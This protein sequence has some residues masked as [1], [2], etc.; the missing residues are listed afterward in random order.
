MKAILALILLALP[1]L[2]Q[3]SV[4]DEIAALEA[5]KA[6]NPPQLL[7]GSGRLKSSR[8]S[9]SAGRC[10]TRL[11][12]ISTAARK[13]PCRRAGNGDGKWS[14][15]NLTMTGSVISR[16]NDNLLKIRDK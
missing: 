1:V 11:H 2:S 12:A 3:A 4:A 7:P 5:A 13:S 14:T 8:I 15:G 9:A 10:S 6:Q 16:R